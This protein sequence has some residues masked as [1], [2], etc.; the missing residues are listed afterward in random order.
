M[1]NPFRDVN[2][3]P[4]TDG[5]RSFAKSIAIG[6]PIVA[7]VLGGMNG[8][9]A[10]TFWLGGIGAATGAALWLLP[11]FARPFYICWNGVGCCIGFVV[12]NIAAAVI[13]YLVITPVGLLLRLCGR[14]PLERG[15]ERE[16]KSYWKAAPKR[17]DAERCFRQY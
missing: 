7:A 6:L 13:Y 4:G 16:R 11:Q 8:W 14:D 15:F 5:K 2:W 10:W 3:N 9:P 1:L 12:S 17:D